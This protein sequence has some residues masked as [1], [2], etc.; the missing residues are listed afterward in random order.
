MIDRSIRAGRFRRHGMGVI[1]SQWDLV[2]Q[3]FM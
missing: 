2:D 3:S 1:G